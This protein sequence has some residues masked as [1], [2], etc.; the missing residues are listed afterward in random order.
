MNLEKLLLVS[1]MW[2]CIIVSEGSGIGVEWMKESRLKMVSSH[3]LTVYE[4]F[5]EIL[6]LATSSALY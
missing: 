6:L 2:V 1:R 5:I 4:S 3:F